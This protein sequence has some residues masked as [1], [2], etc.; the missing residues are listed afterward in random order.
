M[1]ILKCRKFNKD[2]KELK[3]KCKSI[4]IE[5][6]IISQVKK[7]LNEY[8]LENIKVKLF[9]SEGIMLYKTR[10]KGCEKGKRGGI[11]LI[12][13][14][15]KSENLIILLTAYAKSEKENMHLNEIINVLEKCLKEM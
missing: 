2:I 14:I 11:R 7:L 5:K 13:G 12:W 15:S 9:Q 8:R 1:Q 3:K 10:I 6:M 4:D